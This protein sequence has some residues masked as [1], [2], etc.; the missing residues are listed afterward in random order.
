MT[1]V[2]VQRASAG[3]NNNITSRQD[4]N[5][6]KKDENPNIV[7]VSVLYYIEYCLDDAAPMTRFLTPFNVYLLYTDLRYN[8]SALFISLPSKQKG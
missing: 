7:Y 5:V 2:R 3:K 8:Q 4:K 6:N 1:F